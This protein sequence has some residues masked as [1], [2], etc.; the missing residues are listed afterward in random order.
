MLA[1]GVLRDAR[2]QLHWWL[3]H[4][5]RTR[6]SHDL[7]PRA[8]AAG[9]GVVGRGD[10][11]GA[12]PVGAHRSPNPAAPG[13]EI[14]IDPVFSVSHKT[15]CGTRRTAHNLFLFIEAVRNSQ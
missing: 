4:A 12:V 7:I 10:P 1:Q 3:H 8:P 5:A 6:G 14:Q 9:E 15:K 13:L 11:P 2:W